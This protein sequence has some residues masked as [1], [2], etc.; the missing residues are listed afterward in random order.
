M[1]YVAKSEEQL[2]KEGLMPEG[3]Y[4]FEVIDSSDKPSKSGSDMC[5]LKLNVFDA[6]GNGH[7][8]W[9]YMVFGNHFG[10]RKFRHAAVGC[11]LLSVYESGGLTAF[12]FKGKSGRCIIK[13]AEAKDGYLPKN[14][15][16]DYVPKDVQ[17]KVTETTKDP[18]DGDEVP[19]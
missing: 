11:G 5:T 3:E 6:D 2:A 15:V 14:V 7:H 12:E 13:I 17:S 4:D 8:V 19:F 16:A 1:S 10:E 18:L 9:D